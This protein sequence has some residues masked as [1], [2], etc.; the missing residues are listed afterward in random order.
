L[1]AFYE[2]SLLFDCVIA[3]FPFSIRASAVSLSSLGVFEMGEIIGVPPSRWQT[4]ATQNMGK[5]RLLV[6]IPKM[7][8]KK[9]KQR[10]QSALRGRQW[11]A[12]AEQAT[13]DSCLLY[14]VSGPLPPHS[15]RRITKYPV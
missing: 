13:F 15:T 5:M 11:S 10:R 1:T 14:P 4:P 2:S 9:A 8:A 6:G 12:R 7:S 3:E